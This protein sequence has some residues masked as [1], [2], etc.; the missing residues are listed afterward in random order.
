MFSRTRELSILSLSVALVFLPSMS[1]SV[2]AQTKS[3][4]IS[5]ASGP[6]GSG[7]YV[8]AATLARL[9]SKYIP[10]T[11]ATVEATTASADNC[12]LVHMRK[13]D[14]GLTIVDVAYDALKGL[15][16]FKAIGPMSIRA[17]V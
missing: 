13:A 16:K 17:I 9:I 6:V 8:F 10:D 3:V 15:D 7:Y 14:L 2:E 11:E 12:K 4:R 5:L 1:S